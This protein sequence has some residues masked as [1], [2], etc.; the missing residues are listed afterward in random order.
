MNQAWS[1]VSDNR[2]A[3][4]PGAPVQHRQIRCGQSCDCGQFVG[5]HRRQ[6]LGERARRRHADAVAERARDGELSGQ[7]VAEG[8]PI[9]RCVRVQVVLVVPCVAQRR[10]GRDAE[11]A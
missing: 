9:G 6:V 2:T 11:L 10:H 4:T 3:S 1:V 5:E 7:P 8:Q